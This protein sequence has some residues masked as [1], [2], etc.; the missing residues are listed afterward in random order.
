MIR[1]KCKNVTVS[2][3]AASIS[4]ATAGAAFAGVANL[5]TL[6]SQN[7]VDRFIVKYRDGSL[8]SQDSSRMQQ[9]LNKAMATA[10]QLSIN[11]A[12]T[13]A[14]LQ[15]IKPM[16]MSHVRKMALGSDVIRTN[17]K[18]D[19][20]EA[21]VLMKQIAAQPNVEYVQVD[22]MLKPLL[23]P[24]DTNYNVQW[25]YFEATGGLNLPTAWDKATG[26]GVVVAVIDTGITSHSDLNANIVAGYDF[27]SDPD[28]GVDGNGR[29]SDASDNGDW[30][31]NAEC[32][33]PPAPR[34]SN[35][36]W[37]GTH[38]AGTIAAVTN[39]AKGVAG[40]AYGAKVQP[41]RG[42]GKCGG[43]TS[44]IAD[45]IIWAAGGS[46]SGVPANPTPALVIN[47]SLGS[48]GACDAVTQSAINS[49][50]GRGATVVVAAGNS[51]SNVSNF[52]PASCNNVVSVAAIN[53][54]GNRASY[55]NFGRLIDVSAP[56][57]EGGTAGVASTVNAGT[58]TPG[59]ES[60]AYYA[61]TS[62][63]SPHVAGVVALIQ[64]VSPKTPAQ[65]ETLL[66]QTARSLPGTCSGGC[67]SGI[68][69][70]AA[71][72]NAAI[73][74]G[75]PPP[76][77]AG[78]VFENTNNVT[79]VDRGTVFSDITVSGRSGNAP[80]T[81]RVSV[82][83]KHTYRGD[84]Q[85]DLIAPD[86]TA[87]PLKNTSTSDSADNVIGTATVNASSEVANGRWRLR[88]ADIYTGDTGFIDSWRLTF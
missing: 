58:T 18:L 72:V 27:I 43:L 44:D 3:L 47:M 68:V 45:A 10:Q 79:I 69:D 16:S 39:N 5:E 31:R 35:S 75:N 53:R 19:K 37:H 73:G 81:L 9:S 84:L 71:A 6:E 61:G 60:Y 34:E 21:A 70:A 48:D 50:V 55:S 15:A 13:A 76:P 62:M 74:G 86:G 83:I 12:T 87:Y 56:G 4:L 42:L 38:V 2:L 52:T 80:S 40:V 57:G 29:D 46:V 30:H 8:E 66:K 64:S 63:A 26:N 51:N 28:I 23:T 54:Q 25:H 33:P 78:N 85:I 67:G 1:N 65:I 88:V 7:S 49:A 22:R 59:A 41:I 32:G 24:N 77:P 36:S 20:A 11:S 82:D 17:R 14:K